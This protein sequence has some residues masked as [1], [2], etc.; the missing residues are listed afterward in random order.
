MALIS[1]SLHRLGVAERHDQPGA[2]ALRRADRTG[3]K[4]GGGAVLERATG[5]GTPELGELGFCPNHA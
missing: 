5:V 2:L 4:V 1:A 3:K